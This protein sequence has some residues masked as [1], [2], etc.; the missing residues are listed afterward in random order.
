MQGE[1]FGGQGTSGGNAKTRRFK[2]DQV[3]PRLYP[4][5]SISRSEHDVL[6]TRTIAIIVSNGHRYKSD[7]RRTRGRVVMENVEHLPAICIGD[8]AAS[9]SNIFEIINCFIRISSGNVEA[10]STVVVCVSPR[11]AAQL[12]NPGFRKTFEL[13]DVLYASEFAGNKS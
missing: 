1:G 13:R 4:Y 2:L 7:G 10:E 5:I 12:D 9:A 3:Y 6:M 8:I 11:S